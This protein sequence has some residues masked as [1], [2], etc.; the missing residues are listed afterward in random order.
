MLHLALHCW[1]INRADRRR[2]ARPYAR[3]GPQRFF[4]RPQN[5]IKI[6]IEVSKERPQDAAA[7]VALQAQRHPGRIVHWR[8]SS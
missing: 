1:Q 2:D 5:G 3:H 6:M 7:D 4:F 8:Y